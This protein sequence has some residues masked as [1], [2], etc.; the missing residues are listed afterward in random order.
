MQRE[1]SQLVFPIG[2]FLGTAL[3][4]LLARFFAACGRRSHRAYAKNSIIPLLS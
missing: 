2:I 4:R 3:F 1:R